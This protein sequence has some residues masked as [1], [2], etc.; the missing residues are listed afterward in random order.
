MSN[1]NTLQQLN[2]QFDSI[3]DRLI[4]RIL[5]SDGNE[6]RIW[7]TRRY[8]RLLLG[9]IDKIVHPTI[10]AE[11]APHAEEIKAFER[12]A[13]LES[14]N[15]KEEYKADAAENFPLGE[16]PTLASRIDYKKLG[17]GAVALTFGIQGGQNININLD[18]SLLHA[19]VKILKQGSTMAEWNLAASSLKE[20][21]SSSLTSTNKPDTILH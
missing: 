11:K 21:G 15:F 3:Q 19:L 9:V 8:T 5:S 12:D 6:L 4:L 2:I 7:L 14:G 1:T 13:A 16:S 17:N 18:I 10:G 20:A